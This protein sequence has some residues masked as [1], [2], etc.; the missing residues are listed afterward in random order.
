[1]YFMMPMELKERSDIELMSLYNAILM[2]LPKM[3]QGSVRWHMAMLTL[4]YIRRE[5]QRRRA[6]T[7]PKPR[8][9][10]C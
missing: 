1:M 8:G 7:R 9:P 3:E 5:E 4:D 10:G 2:E 6:V